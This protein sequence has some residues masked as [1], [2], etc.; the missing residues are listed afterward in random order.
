MFDCEIK[1]TAS[2]ST[3]TKN[4]FSLVSKNSL[5]YQSQSLARPRNE[6]KKVL[7]EKVYSKF[8]PITDT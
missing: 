4:G 1:K 5:S 2:S 3:D 7:F 6:N 8:T